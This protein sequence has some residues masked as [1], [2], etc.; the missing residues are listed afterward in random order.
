MNVHVSLT[1]APVSSASVHQ[2]RSDAWNSIYVAG[3]HGKGV[4]HLEAVASITHNMSLISVKQQ[5][6]CHVYI[7]KCPRSVLE[8]T[9][10]HKD[11]E[12]MLRSISY[13]LHLP[14]QR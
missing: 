4:S 8:H 7:A 12:K 1:H 2:T 13:M 3:A 10:S 9:H 5:F 14:G 6:H 11:P